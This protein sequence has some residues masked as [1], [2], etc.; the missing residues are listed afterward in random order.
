MPLK[1]RAIHW[2]DA[3]DAYA[4]AERPELGWRAGRR[5]M[6]P[7]RNLFGTAVHQLAATQGVAAMPEL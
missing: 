6:P 4:D 2:D 5:D 3:S 7:S 1:R